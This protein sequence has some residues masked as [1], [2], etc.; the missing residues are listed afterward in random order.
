MIVMAWLGCVGNSLAQEPALLEGLWEPVRKGVSPETI[1][2]YE[3]EGLLSAE[4]EA[5]RAAWA[6]EENDDTAQCQRKSAAALGGL[7]F[8][9]TL[10]FL[11]EDDVIYM[12]GFEQIRRVY[13]DG[14]ERPTGFW[15]NKLGWSQGDWEGETLVVTTTD[16]TEGTIDAGNRPLP[17]GGPD[18]EMVERYTLTPE[19]RALMLDLTLTDPKYYVAPIRVRHEFVPSNQTV[20]APDCLPSVY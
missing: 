16:F 18:A 12:L 1:L 2:D 20:L 13:I 19:P 8:G 15:P 17:F 9:F 4:A 6:I 5:F 10:E 14:R 7:E 11:T 3:A